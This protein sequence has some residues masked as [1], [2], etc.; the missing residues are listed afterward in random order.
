MTQRGELI[1]IFEDP[2]SLPFKVNATS[3]DDIKRQYRQ[4]QHANDPW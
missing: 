1:K 4:W 3:A 2:S